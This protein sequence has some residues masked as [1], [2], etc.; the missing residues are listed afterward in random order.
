MTRRGWLSFH[1][2]YLLL[3][4]MLTTAVTVCTSSLLLLSSFSLSSLSIS[5]NVPICI[6]HTCCVLF[7]GSFIKRCVTSNFWVLCIK[8]HAPHSSAAF[9]SQWETSLDPLDLPHFSVCGPLD[10][11]GLPHCKV[12]GP[13]AYL[14]HLHCRVCGPFDPLDLQHC[15]VCEPFGTHAFQGLWAL[16]LPHCRV[17]GP[18]GPPTLQHLCLKIGKFVT[19]H[20]KAHQ[21]VT[22]FCS[23]TYSSCVCTD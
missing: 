19:Q 17:S 22:V 14:G 1:S 4:S 11:L 7:D 2:T 10:Y 12:C 20:F 6:T 23:V 13:L 16:G 21:N 15:R 5:Q 3:D 9:F 8:Q 18:F